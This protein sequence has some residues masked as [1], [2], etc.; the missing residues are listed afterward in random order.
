MAGMELRDIPERLARMGRKQRDLADHLQVDPSTVSKLIKGSR[1]LQIS[2]VRAIEAFFGE[3][4][5][6]EAGSARMRPS[7]GGGRPSMVPVYGYTAAGAEDRIALAQDQV[8]EWRE[9]PPYWNGAGDLFYVRVIGESM[10][11]RYF[12][13]EIV[14]VRRNVTPG[15]DDDC[16]VELL[17]GTALLK[18]F[19]SRSDRQLRLRQYNPPQ[20][21][22][23]IPRS[24]VRAVHTVWRPR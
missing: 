16:V 8:L 15:R 10:A 13:G 1:G 20:D 22:E 5:D 17:N 4:L 7:V 23:P 6:I 14:P 9:P 3:T 21:V 24:D 12:S 19:V 18:V 2:E 11:P